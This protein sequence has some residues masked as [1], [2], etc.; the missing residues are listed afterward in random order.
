MYDTMRK[1][2]DS[3]KGVP[4]NVDDHERH[5]DIAV[6]LNAPR[7]YGRSPIEEK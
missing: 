4:Q 5:G 1:S 3:I 7:R 2:T 6:V